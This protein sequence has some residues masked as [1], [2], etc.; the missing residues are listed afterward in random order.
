MKSRGFYKLF[1]ARLAD[2][3]SLVHAMIVIVAAFGWWLVPNHPI[4]LLILLLTLASW[5]FTGSCVLAHVEY[6]LRKK[7]MDAVPTYEYGYLHY[8]LHRLTKYAP[9]IS[10]IRTWGYVYLISA[11]VLWI[12]TQY[13]IESV[14][15]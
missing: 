8:H 5:V 1:Y 7:Y 13:V 11:V 14:V 10:F 15:S 4:H 6:R 12:A 9:S 3:V 2:L